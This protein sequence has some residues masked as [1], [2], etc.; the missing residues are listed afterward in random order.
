MYFYA[1]FYKLTPYRRS[2]YWFL[3]QNILWD[4]ISKAIL[5]ASQPPSPCNP[6]PLDYFIIDDPDLLKDVVKI[7]MG[8]K[9]YEKEMLIVIVGNLDAHFDKTDRHVKHIDASLANMTMMLALE[10]LS[11]SICSINGPDMEG[12]KRKMEKVLDLK[13]TNVLSCTWQ[14]VT[15]IPKEWLLFQ[16]REI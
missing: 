5:A 12:L 6:Q 10:T 14:W 7:P 3:N 2:V 11:L 8:I 16:K 13:N 1:E 4:I 15:P 9:G